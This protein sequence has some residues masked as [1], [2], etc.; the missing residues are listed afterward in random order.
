MSDTDPTT[1]DGRTRLRPSRGLQ[2]APPSNSNSTDLQGLL[3]IG[4]P[5]VA[6]RPP[7]FRKDDYPT[8]ILDKLQWSLDYAKQHRLRP[9]LLG[10]LFDFP[11]DNANWLLVRLLHMLD[12]TLAISGNHDCKENSLGETTPSPSSSPPARYASS[13]KTAPGSPPS[14]PAPSS[15][16]APAGA[17]KSRSP[18]I[19]PRTSFTQDSALRTQHLSSG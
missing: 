7:G 1:D 17:K 2:P 12:G 19:P 9:V 14:T 3:F 18:L 4:D 11:R 15:S 8:A 6:S 16:A 10:D 13:P 5:H